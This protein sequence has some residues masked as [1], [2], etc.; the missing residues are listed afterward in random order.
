MLQIELE[1]HTISCQFHLLRLVLSTHYDKPVPIRD[2]TLAS[3]ARIDAIYL[4]DSCSG[5]CNG[6]TDKKLETR[7]VHLW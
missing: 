7:N 1:C 6:L 2:S 4:K 3:V 5:S